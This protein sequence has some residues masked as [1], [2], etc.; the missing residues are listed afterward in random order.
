MG[1]ISYEIASGHK[2]GDVTDEIELKARANV[3]AT[4]FDRK[5]TINFLTEKF[6]ENLLRGTNKERAIHPDTLRVSNVISRTEDDSEIKATLE[7]NASTVYDF[8][9]ASNE[10]T[11]RLKIIIAGTSEKD[12][13]DHL[14]NE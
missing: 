8:E 2:V 4:V 12:A 14:I 11:R 9:N 7:M 5:A 13:L 10:L 3:T 1:E 6:R